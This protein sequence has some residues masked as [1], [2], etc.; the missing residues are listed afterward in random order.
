[1]RLAALAARVKLLGKISLLYDNK[2]EINKPKPKP[3]EQKSDEKT[4]IKEE[5]GL[6]LRC[7]NLVRLMVNK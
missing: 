3:V 7:L 5:N 2:I 1:M 4:N 6:E